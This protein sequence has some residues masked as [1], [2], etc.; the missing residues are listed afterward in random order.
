MHINSWPILEDG[1]EPLLCAIVVPPVNAELLVPAYSKEVKWA[2]ALHTLFT[3][4]L[5]DAFQELQPLVRVHSGPGDL[6]VILPDNRGYI[7]DIVIIWVSTVHEY[8]VVLVRLKVCDQCAD[9]VTQVLIVEGV[10]EDV[11]TISTADTEVYRGIVGREGCTLSKD[12]EARV[13]IDDV[14]VRTEPVL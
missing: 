9:Q 5:N 2:L 6:S 8:S 11:L 12:N 7:K 3:P 10:H 4:L 14:A 13:L 1:L